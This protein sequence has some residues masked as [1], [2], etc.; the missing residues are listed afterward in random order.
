MGR[1]DTAPLP[2]GWCWGRGGMH[3]RG[4]LGRKSALFSIYNKTHQRQPSRSSFCQAGVTILS[5]MIKDLFALPLPLRVRK[6]PSLRDS[7]GTKEGAALGRR[8]GSFHRENRKH[9][10]FLKIN[11][12]ILSYVL[13]V[14]IWSGEL[15]H[16]EK[17]KNGRCENRQNKPDFTF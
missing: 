6:R 17:L 3:P 13:A 7:P 11:D 10:T 14:I 8:A 15:L 5:S 1:R 2:A 16:K 4:V 9:V 12:T